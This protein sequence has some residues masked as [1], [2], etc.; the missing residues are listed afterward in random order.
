M[1]KKLITQKTYDD[2]AELLA[3]EYNSYGAKV[4]DIDRGFSFVNKRNPFV[5]EIGCGNGRDAKEILLRTSDYTGID[6]SFSM[7][8][9]ARRTAPQGH[10]IVID[11]EDFEFLFS[12]Q[13]DIIFSFASLLHFDRK[14]LKIIFDRAYEKLSDDG[15]FYIF[16]KYGE[17]KE[18]F[19][20]DKYG[21]RVFFY[22]LPKDI[23]RI[24]GKRFAVVYEKIYMLRG[25]E[26]FT[27]ILKK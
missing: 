12:Q 6:S 19:K 24:A 11:A 17:Y 5:F 14:A 16:L 22:Y 1:D 4:E 25:Q 2:S 3:E 7:I 21:K 13:I 9:I 27:I 8:K 20:E 18:V 15:I 26:W 23:K 10:F